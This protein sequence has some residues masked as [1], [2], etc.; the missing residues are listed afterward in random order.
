[1]AAEWARWNLGRQLALE[2]VREAEDHIERH[3]TRGKREEGRNPAPT[4]TTEIQESNAATEDSHPRPTPTLASLHEHADGH[5]DTVSPIFHTQA[6]GTRSAFTLGTTY[7][8]NRTG[9][10]Q[11]N[12]YSKLTQTAEVGAAGQKEERACTCQPAVAAEHRGRKPL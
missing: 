10:A 7:N 5:L 4:T 3:V 12:N 2:T 8:E 11:H 6:P 9:T 1:M